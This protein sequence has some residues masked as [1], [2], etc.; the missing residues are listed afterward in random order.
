MAVDAAYGK[1]KRS[2]STAIVTGAR[3]MSASFPKI[4]LL[5]AWKGRL[6]LDE[7]P[8]AILTKYL[9]WAPESVGIENTLWQASLIRTMRM[10][11]NVPFY[12]I[13]R[14]KQKN[15]D[16]QTRAGALAFHYSEGHIFHPDD[17]PPWLEAFEK[18]LLAFTGIPGRDE[19][20]DY[21]DAFVDVVDRLTLT[22]DRQDDDQEPQELPSSWDADEADFSR[23]VLLNDYASERLKLL[24]AA[25]E[26]SEQTRKEMARR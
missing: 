25:R 17:N 9:E 26:A 22:R 10:Q 15:A 5:D 8:D 21:V 13:D 18:E 2:D 23:A 4:H 6:A 12:E 3:D 19:H 16:K 1:S 11:G 7:I 20:D 24:A 14:R